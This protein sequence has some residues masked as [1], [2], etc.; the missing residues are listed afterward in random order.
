MYTILHKQCSNQSDDGTA[1][2]VGRNTDVN[3]GNSLGTDARETKGTDKVEQWEISAIGFEGN[4]YLCCTNVV[5]TALPPQ[6]YIIA[7]Y[8][9]STSTD[10]E[11]FL[12]VLASAANQIEQRDV[13]SV[14]PFMFSNVSACL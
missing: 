6:T 5:G 12:S 2:Q 4:A 8:K 11:F 9:T 1:E 3:K 10:E 14:L 7:T 13:R